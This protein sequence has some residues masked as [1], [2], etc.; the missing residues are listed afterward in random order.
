VF[1][2]VAGAGG[3]IE[4]RAGFVVADGVFGFVGE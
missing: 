2:E 3:G 4:D 1:V